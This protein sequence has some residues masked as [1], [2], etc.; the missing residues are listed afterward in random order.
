MRLLSFAAE[1]CIVVVVF[2]FFFFFFFLGSV[3][4]ACPVPALP[5]AR[6]LLTRCCEYVRSAAS[7]NDASPSIM[8]SQGHLTH[9]S[10]QRVPS[11]SAT[12]RCRIVS[13]S[14]AP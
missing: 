14:K 12:F 11:Y 1:A 3:S 4:D 13:M 9:Q 8:G 5:S 7:G 6:G 2:F 10:A